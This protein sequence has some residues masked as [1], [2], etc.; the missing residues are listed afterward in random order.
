MPPRKTHIRIPSV[1]GQLGYPPDLVKQYK[2]GNGNGNGSGK[3]AT[4]GRAPSASPARDAP[5]PRRGQ[6]DAEKNDPPR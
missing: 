1:E 6:D 5:A 4:H 2:N 3:G